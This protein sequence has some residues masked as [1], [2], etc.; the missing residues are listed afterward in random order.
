MRRSF[1]RLSGKLIRGTGSN[2]LKQDETNQIEKQAHH[3]SFL[4]SKK[5]ADDEYFFNYNKEKS[6]LLYYL[7]IDYARYKPKLLP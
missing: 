3:G 7:C 4:P 2:N 5:M 1:H 6:E